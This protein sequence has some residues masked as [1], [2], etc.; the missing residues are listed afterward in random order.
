MLLEQLLAKRIAAPRRGD[1][2]DD[3]APRASPRRTTAARVSSDWEREL[4]GNNDL[5]SLTQPRLVR[6]IHAQ[7][8]AGGRRHPRDQHLQL[9]LDRAGRLRHGALGPR[10]QSRRG[11]RSRAT[12]CGELAGDAP[13]QPRFVA[14]V[15]GPD[16]Q[17]RLASR[18]DVNDPGFRAVTFD[19]LV[20]AYSEAIDGTGRGRRRPAAGRDDLRHAQREGG[21]VRDRQRVR[22]TAA[23]RLPVMISGTITDASGRTLSGQ[24][25]EAFCNSVRHARP[26]AVGLNCALGAKRAAPVRRGA[27]ADRRDASSACHPNAGLPNAFG[28]YEETPESMSRQHRRMGARRLAQHRRRLLRHDARAH[29][30][31]RARRWRA[32]RRARRAERPRRAAPVGPGAA[33]RR[34]AVALRQ[35][36]RAH[37]RHRLEGLRAPDPRGRLSPERWR[38]RASRSRTAPR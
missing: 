26:L 6:D 8:L 5:L 19:Q 12:P 36:R 32:S 23:L 31:D 33:Q 27:R 25:A 15:L 4:R 9:D 37:Q 3:P 2:H 29:P 28:E 11:A 21:A 13:R 35:R 7:Y 16:E 17:D 30:R 22:S 18:P 10:T 24:T 34:R 38:W 1:G 20:A 14:G